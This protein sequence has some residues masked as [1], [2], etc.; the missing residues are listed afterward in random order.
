M[1]KHSFFAFV[2][3]LVGYAE[4]RLVEVHRAQI[5]L[6]VFLALLSLQVEN[7][8][9]GFDFSVHRF[10]WGHEALMI[11]HVRL[12]SAQFALEVAAAVFLNLFPL[13]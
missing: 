1:F 7:N 13:Q 3:E 10:R 2:T 11:F 9:G 4:I 8:K 12:F 5:G 6:L